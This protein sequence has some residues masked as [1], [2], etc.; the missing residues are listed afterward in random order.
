[1]N[2][3]LSRLCDVLVALSG[4]NDVMRVGATAAMSELLWR[5]AQPEDVG[6]GHELAFGAALRV[7]AAELE[8]GNLKLPE[9][10]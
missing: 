1:M 3:P 9:V 8:R 6:R 10:E 7:V 4:D 5:P 2:A